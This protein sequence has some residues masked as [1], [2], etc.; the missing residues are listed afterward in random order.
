MAHVL[1]V[2]VCGKKSSITAQPHPALPACALQQD[3]PNASSN[4]MLGRWWEAMKHGSG[5]GLGRTRAGRGKAAPTTQP[6]MEH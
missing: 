3:T 2:K 1:L 4:C 6:C 5:T